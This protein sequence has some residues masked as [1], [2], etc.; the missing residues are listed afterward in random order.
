MY[1]ICIKIKILEI[2]LQL[3]MLA[4]PKIFEK[5]DFVT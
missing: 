1:V 2:L 5:F 4:I 3:I